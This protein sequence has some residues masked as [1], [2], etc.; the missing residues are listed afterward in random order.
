MEFNSGFKGLRAKNFAGVHTT[1]FVLLAFVGVGY[2]CIITGSHCEF[3]NVLKLIFILLFTLVT[4]HICR[5]T[6]TCVS[7]EM[8]LCSMQK[9]CLRISVIVLNNSSKNLLLF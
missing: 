9:V 2:T 8:L 6:D 5:N 4:K 1:L 7:G 3:S